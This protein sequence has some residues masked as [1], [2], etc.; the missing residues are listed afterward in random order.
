MDVGHERR[1]VQA[2]CQRIHVVE[3]ECKDQ[4]DSVPWDNVLQSM[5]SVVVRERWDNWG[6]RYRK[7]LVL[8]VRPIMQ[9]VG[10]ELISGGVE[11][12]ILVFLG[13]IE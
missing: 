11:C 2:R 1:L 7:G 6:L 3:E 8:S 13:T 9:G 10:V 5:G 4:K 12:L